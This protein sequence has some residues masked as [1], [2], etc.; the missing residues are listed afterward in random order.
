MFF[1][2]IVGDELSFTLLSRVPST[3]SAK[4]SAVVH[5]SRA[6][7]APK[8]FIERTVG[9]FSQQFGQKSFCS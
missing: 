7:S 9:V 1:G 2:E 5:S 3:A 6:W 4:G 8:I